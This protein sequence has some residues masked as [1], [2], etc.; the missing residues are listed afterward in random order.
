MNKTCCTCKW[1][2]D[3]GGVCFNVN[4]EFCADFT[5]EDDSCEEWEESDHES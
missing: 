2:D 4:S 5:E 3:F 1:R